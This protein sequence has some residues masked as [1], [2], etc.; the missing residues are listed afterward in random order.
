MMT[1]AVVIVQFIAI[2]A[3]LLVIANLRARIIELKNALKANDQVVDALR[4]QRNDAHRERNL[5]ND[6]FREIKKISDYSEA[7]FSVKINRARA[8]FVTIRDLNS[9]IEEALE[10]YFEQDKLDKLE[11]RPR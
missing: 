3:T 11:G 9:N 2:I 10:Q 1:E 8:L 7:Y 6:S 4:D 5:A